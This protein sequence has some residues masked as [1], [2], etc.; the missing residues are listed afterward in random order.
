MA[1]LSRVTENISPQRV[2]LQ[3]CQDEP[4]SFP[5]ESHPLAW[6]PTTLSLVWRELPSLIHTSQGNCEDQVRLR[7]E[8]HFVNWNAIQSHRTVI[9]TT[10][11]NISRGLPPPSHHTWFQ[12]EIQVSPKEKC[13]I[14]DLFMNGSHSWK[15][16]TNIYNSYAKVCQTYF[17]SSSSIPCA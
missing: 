6:V 10:R 1:G 9:S 15:M 3:N 12:P 17:T 8:R 2:Q 5:G 11:L 13:F 16:P 7:T 14:W 4:E